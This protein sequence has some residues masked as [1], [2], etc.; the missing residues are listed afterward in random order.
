MRAPRRLD[1]GDI[2]GYA[3]IA[4]RRL[5]LVD[6]RA[7][8]TRRHWEGAV[9]ERPHRRESD[10]GKLATV[11][12]NHRGVA[13]STLPLACCL[14]QRHTRA[15][16]DSELIYRGHPLDAAGRI[17]PKWEAER[18]WDP[19]GVNTPA[20]SGSNDTTIELATMGVDE[21]VLVRAPGAAWAR[22]ATASPEGRYGGWKVSRWFEERSV[23]DRPQGRMVGG[24]ELKEKSAEALRLKREWTGAIVR[25]REA[26]RADVVLPPRT[27]CLVLWS[28]A[29]LE[30]ESL[31]CAV[32]G[33]QMRMGRIRPRTA[34][35]LGHVVDETGE[36]MRDEAVRASA[37]MMALNGGGDARAATRWR[38]SARQGATSKWPPAAATDRGR[39][40]ERC[41]DARTDSWRSATRRA[42]SRS[43]NRADTCRDRQCDRAGRENASRRAASRRF[44]TGPAGR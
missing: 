9:V 30:V 33:Q 41:T 19:L 43:R 16:S 25:L 29:G 21:Q 14:T 32:C 31:P 27:Y 39:S 44:E 40:R 4:G 11:T 22:V 34:E 38:L 42:I 24:Y 15:G 10:P 37:S 7:L 17:M 20:P 36:P 5:A 6:E 3:E 13:L 1:Q 12:R 23:R 28:Y 35:Y 18:S 26:V 8:K 2:R